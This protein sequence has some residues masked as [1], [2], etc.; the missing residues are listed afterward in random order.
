MCLV[1]RLSELQVRGGDRSIT[2]L[3][4]ASHINGSLGR[5]PQ[6]TGTL[7]EVGHAC[8]HDR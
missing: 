2:P 8:R 6:M 3:D 5:I 1:Q 7:E 4:S